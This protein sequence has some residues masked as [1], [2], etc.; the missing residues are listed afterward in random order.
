LSVT[1]FVSQPTV[2]DTTGSA[3]IAQSGLT[4]N[5]FTGQFSGTVSFTNTTATPISGSTLQFELEGLSAGVTLDNKS[6]EVNGIPYITLPG[7]TIAPGA[8]V[9]VQTLFGNPSKGT[10]A[11][12]PKLYSI[13][14]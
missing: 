10:I 3:K 9:S 1:T 6:G 5:R 7:T 4:V 2:N 13:T 11:Y 8:T 12:T 14:Y